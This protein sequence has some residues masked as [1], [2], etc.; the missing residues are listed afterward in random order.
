[1]GQ[2]LSKTDQ[3]LLK[4]PPLLLYLLLPFPLLCGRLWLRSWLSLYLYLLLGCCF[5]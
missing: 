1:M 5:P 3:M 4:L 2:L